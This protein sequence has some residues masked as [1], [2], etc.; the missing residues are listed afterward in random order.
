MGAE[1]DKGSIFILLGSRNGSLLE[2]G[3]LDC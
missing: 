1:M 3:L 2:E